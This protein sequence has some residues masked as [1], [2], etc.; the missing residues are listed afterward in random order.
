MKRRF[1]RIYPLCRLNLPPA[2]EPE[3]PPA[4]RDEVLYEGYSP[5]LTRLAQV[6]L[7]A[8]IVTAVLAVALP[9]LVSGHAADRTKATARTSAPLGPAP[10]APVAPAAGPVPGFYAALTGVTSP[11]YDHPRGITIRDTITGSVLA[12]VKPPAPYGTFALVAHGNSAGTY[13]VGVQMWQPAYNAS[14]AASNDAAPITLLLMNYDPAGRHVSFTALPT[15]VLPGLQAGGPALNAAALSPDGTRLAVAVQP[16][17]EELDLTVYSLTGGTPRTWP[18]RGA[19]ISRYH[20]AVSRQNPSALSWLADND[21]LVFNMTGVHATGT[22]V[23]DIR[24]LDVSGPGGDLL[25]ASQL[26]FSARQG[27]S[28]LCA[29]SLLMSPDGS[30]VAC[31]G[32]TT[33]SGHGSRPG[34]PPAGSKQHSP[35]VRPGTTGAAQPVSYGIAE[36]SIAT[37][38][39]TGILARTLAASGEPASPRLYWWDGLN[40]L[41]ATYNGPVFVLRQGASQAIPWDQRISP[42][43]GGGN[44]A[45]W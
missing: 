25:A 4:D 43:Q 39:L 22:P 17:P 26:L 27:P 5:R 45:A 7:A 28:F 13:L 29:G 2:R 16:S 1:A 23:N 30:T 10:A 11:G 38:N 3:A 14:H 19:A 9:R 12:T 21:T 15:P 34:Q 35:A 6:M 36:F 40:S 33:P 18:V 41:I 31:A 32:R 8:V 44:D 24:E 37:G 42:P 20:D